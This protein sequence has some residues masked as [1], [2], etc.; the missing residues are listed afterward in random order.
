[1]DSFG[2]MVQS[3]G[4]CYLGSWTKGVQYPNCTHVVVGELEAPSL[5]SQTG[6]LQV[7]SKFFQKPDKFRLRAGSQ[8]ARI[9]E[10]QRVPNIDFALDTRSCRLVA[11]ELKEKL[12]EV[13]AQSESSLAQLQEKLSEA[14]AGLE[15]TKADLKELNRKNAGLRDY[16]KKKLHRCAFRFLFQNKYRRYHPREW[17]LCFS[18]PCSYNGSAEERVKLAAQYIKR[19]QARKDDLQAARLKKNRVAVQR[20]AEVLQAMLVDPNK[21][22][23]MQ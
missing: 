23:G 9:R 15:R 19:A 5:A 14:Q 16:I 10:K 4:C 13:Q 1:M 17:A 8:P 18:I 2:A 11:A 20:L 12:S 21:S 3:D 22:S 6:Q 7:C